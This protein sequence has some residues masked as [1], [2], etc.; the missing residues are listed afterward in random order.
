MYSGK[1]V[2]ATR[3]IKRRIVHKEGGQEQS[4]SALCFCSRLDGSDQSVHEEAERGE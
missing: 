1:L 2:G 3:E 4:L